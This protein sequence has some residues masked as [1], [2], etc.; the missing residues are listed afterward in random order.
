MHREHDYQF[1]AFRNGKP[2]WATKAF[3]QIVREMK[4]HDGVSSGILADE[5]DDK[6]PKEWMELALKALQ[7]ATDFYIVEVIAK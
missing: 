7:N 3:N 4:H 2:P 6:H 1:R 5:F